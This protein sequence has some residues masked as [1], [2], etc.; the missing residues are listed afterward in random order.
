MS[1]KWLQLLK[2]IAPRVT[3][4]AVLR[5][6]SLASGSGQLGAIQAVGPL[7]GVEVSPIDVRDGA[8]IERAL[9]E[10][11]R[12]PNGGLIVTSSG[13]GAGLRN[14]DRIIA[15]AARHQL[16]AVYPLRSFVSAGGLISFAS[17]SARIVA[18]RASPASGWRC[19]K[20]SHRASRA[21]RLGPI[22]RRPSTH[23]LRGASSPFVS[24]DALSVLS[25]L[26][27]QALKPPLSS[28][29]APHSGASRSSH[30]LFPGALPNQE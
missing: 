11:A 29:N 15:L 9:T 5:D 7:L 13:I 23:F 6:P 22:P 4:A 12:S 25:D 2:E 24:M 18:Q 30:T 1:G 10:F 27:R 26:L 17:D 19:S 3:R 16:R 20:R 28:S 8:E 14:R 21:P